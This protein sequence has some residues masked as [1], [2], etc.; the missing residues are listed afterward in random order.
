MK[1]TKEELIER[2]NVWRAISVFY[3][4]TELDDKDYNNTA[5]ILIESNIE[6]EEL[7]LI[8][9]YEIFP[10]LQLN[11]LSPAGE[12]AGFNSTWLNERCLKNYERRNSSRSFRIFIKL[13]NKFNYWMRKRHWVAIESRMNL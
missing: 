5:K 3:L 13:I 1:L 7:K 4:D 9:L 10:T 6:I 2:Q 8:D 11:L 12:W